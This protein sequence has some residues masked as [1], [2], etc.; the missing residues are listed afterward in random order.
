MFN[1]E[2]EKEIVIKIENDSWEKKSKNKKH[3][4]NS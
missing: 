4:S 3:F 1:N 2:I